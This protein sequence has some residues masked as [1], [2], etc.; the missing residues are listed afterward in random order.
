M[1]TEIKYFRC[2]GHPQKED[3]EEALKIA[4]KYHCFV[5]IEWF[6]QYSGIQ[7]RIFDENATLDDILNGLPKIYG[8]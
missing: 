5:K 1:L 7:S 2:D 8:I 6:I 3:I 4:K